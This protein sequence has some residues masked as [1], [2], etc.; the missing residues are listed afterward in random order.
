MRKRQAFQVSSVERLEDRLVLA[1]PGL[2]P[3]AV[4]ALISQAYTAFEVR[5]SQDIQDFTDRLT[6]A[7]VNGAAIAIPNPALQP[8]ITTTDAFGNT[9]TLANPK[10]NPFANPFVFADAASPTAAFQSYFLA[11]QNNVNT[12]ARQLNSGLGSLGVGSAAHRAKLRSAIAIQLTGAPTNGVDFST[13]PQVGSL[14][15]TLLS[16]GPLDAVAQKPVIVQ[17]PNANKPNSPQ[18]TAG[19][20]IPNPAQKLIAI[21]GQSS[22]NAAEQSRVALTLQAQAITRITRSLHRR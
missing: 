15:R 16:T 8:T 6:G 13:L 5:L 7:A 20:V 1:A 14:S 11:L 21:V 22:I 3:G 12:L 19:A 18:N 4:A 2:R 17:R 9:V 10:F